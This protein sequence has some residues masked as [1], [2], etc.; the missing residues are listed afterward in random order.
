[1]ATLIGSPPRTCLSWATATSQGK[2]RSRVVLAGLEWAAALGVD[3][4]LTVPGDTPFIP[5]GWL[6]RWLLRQPARR[7]MGARTIW[8]HSGRSRAATNLRRLLST[9][10]RRDIAHFAS[11]IGMRRIDFAVAKW[12]PFLNVNTPEDL[13]LARTIAEGET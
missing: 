13:A 12:D 7:A 9:P 10:G 8:S 1:M 5:R 3:A 2:G 11:A 6:P 4:L